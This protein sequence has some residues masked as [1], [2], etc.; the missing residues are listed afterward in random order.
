MILGIDMTWEE[1]KQDLANVPD[2]A[3]VQFRLVDEHEIREGEYT[4]GCI[5]HGK[6]PLVRI[7]I[8]AK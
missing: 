5:E 7:D 3:E 1:I 6:K 4:G 8:K 2:D